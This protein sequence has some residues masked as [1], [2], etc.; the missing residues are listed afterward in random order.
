MAIGVVQTRCVAIHYE[1]K[2]AERHQAGAD[3]RD[4]RH[5]GDL[6]PQMIDVANHFVD[7][8]TKKY[9]LQSQF[10]SYAYGPTTMVPSLEVSLLHTSC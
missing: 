9:L 10:L 3:V 5:S 2:I 7:R 1:T 6:F 4:F 8:E